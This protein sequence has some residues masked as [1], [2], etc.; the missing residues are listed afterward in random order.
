M[1]WLVSMCLAV[2]ILIFVCILFLESRNSAAR[3][4]YILTRCAKIPW[5]SGYML[6][7][8]K[9]KEKRFNQRTKSRDEFLRPVDVAKV[10][11]CVSFCNGHKTFSHV[12]AVVLPDK[13][14]CFSVQ[15][16][17][18]SEETKNNTSRACDTNTAPPKGFSSP[19][20]SPT[21]WEDSSLKKVS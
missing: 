6:L 10:A 15:M 14:E 12:S 19:R 1:N 21:I 13:V 3:R 11:A 5:E 18:R 4:T 20:P 9:K 17:I 8:V 2:V 7:N 16:N